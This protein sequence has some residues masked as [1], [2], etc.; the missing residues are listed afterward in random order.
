MGNEKLVV[1]EHPAKIESWAVVM[2][3][4]H[5]RILRAKATTGY[6]MVGI[7]ICWLK[8]HVDLCFGK[9]CFRLQR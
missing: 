5:F 3:S 7:Q 6:A 4:A 1:I 9:L 8:R 2:T